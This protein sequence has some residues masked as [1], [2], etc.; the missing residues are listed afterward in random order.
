MADT[1]TKSSSTLLLDKLKGKRILFVT[2]HFDD[3]SLFAGG[4]LTRLKEQ[5][6]ILCMHKTYMKRDN[7]EIFYE[8]FLRVIKQLNAIAILCGFEPSK[9]KFMEGRAAEYCFKCAIMTRYLK[10]HRKYDVIITHNAYGEYGHIDHRI[11]YYACRLAF[12]DKEMYTFGYPLKTAN[13]IVE[14]D[15]EK[16][17]QLIDCYLPAWNPRGYSFCYEPE[18]YLK[19]L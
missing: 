14:Y 18:T 16:K 11:V 2:A 13:L 3:E 4:L 12:Q 5:P 10:R 15:I 6:H 19:I 9:E 7:P 17:K 8:G 1:S